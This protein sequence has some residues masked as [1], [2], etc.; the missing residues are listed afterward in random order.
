MTAALIAFVL[1]A[2]EPP[3][4]EAA[5]AKA[6]SRLRVGKLEVLIEAQFSGKTTVIGGAM[7]EDGESNVTSNENFSV[8]LRLKARGKVAP[9]AALELWA[10]PVHAAA[11]AKNGAPGEPSRSCHGTVPERYDAWT[12]IGAA[13]PLSHTQ[14]VRSDGLEW[15]GEVPPAGP[16]DLW[17]RGTPS[18]AASFLRE[19]LHTFLVRLVDARGQVHWLESPAINYV[20]SMCAAP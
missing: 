19:A 17:V 10:R 12:A 1:L 15:S 20:V 7:R 3:A 16:L 5:P 9:I 14:V 8:K 18:E 2:A 13:Q 11:G 4:A 6:P